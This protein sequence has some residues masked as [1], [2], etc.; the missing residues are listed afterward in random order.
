LNIP[1]GM[2]MNCQSANVSKRLTAILELRKETLQMLF[3]LI[4]HDLTEEERDASV[5]FEAQ[6]VMSVN[7]P[8]TASGLEVARFRTKQLYCREQDFVININKYI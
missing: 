3:P 5:E 8:T 7:S 6:K 2:K 1:G 4:R